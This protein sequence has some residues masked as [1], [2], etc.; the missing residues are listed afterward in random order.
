LVARILAK[1]L[2]APVG[3]ELRRLRSLT[4]GSA[5]LVLLFDSNKAL[6][7]ASRD[8][9]LLDAYPSDNCWTRFIEHIH[10]SDRMH[11]RQ[12]LRDIWSQPGRADKLEFRI[13]TEIGTRYVNGRICNMLN[14]FDVQGVAVYLSD[15]TARWT[16]DDLTRLHSR[17]WFVDRLDRTN[18]THRETGARYS[19]LY[20][21][22]NRYDDVRR[23]LGGEVGDALLR[24]TASRLRNRLR[25][26]DPV[27]RLGD[28]TFGV[29]LENVD[30]GEDAEHFASNIEHAIDSPFFVCG[31][32]I[33]TTVSVGIVTSQSVAGGAE[34]VLQAAA[35]AVRTSRPRARSYHTVYEA[36]VQA[37]AKDR[38]LLELDLRSAL[39]RN[40]FHLV[41]Q[42]IHDVQ[43]NRIAGCEALIRWTHP[44]RGFISPD[45]FIPIAEETGLINEIGEWVLREACRQAQSWN[46]RGL[47]LPRMS[48]NVSAD[49]L[50]AGF[51][52]VIDD[53]VQSTGLDTCFLRLE[54]TETSIIDS[55]DEAT[56]T[57]LALKQRGIALALDDFGTGFSSLSYLH[58]FPFDTIKI[59]RAFIK[60]LGTPNSD[61]KDAALVK[62]IVG[63]GQNLEMTTVA[64]GIETQEQLEMVT[65]WGCDYGQGY[66]LA[67]PM[68]ADQLSM[69]LAS[70]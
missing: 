29:I 38:I 41:Y 42:P 37:Q 28:N 33:R 30:S 31:Q 65:S 14:D 15:V 69:I 53:V 60:N 16:L 2:N 48:I 26:A 70:A 34:D 58:R 17:P 5:D 45:K 21:K 3:P 35:S 46:S 64:E 62:T 11:V 55:P 4:N 44:D 43:A 67:R 8:S 32:E 57:L 39:S 50:N 18:V 52:A 13:E 56:E 7:F 36:Q 40:Q 61:G 1:G 22:L 6:T 66:F 12:A 20:I 49:Q 63:L 47:T 59:D 54:V 23:S 51:L 19:V 9:H 27:A 10:A 68:K 24:A 25:R